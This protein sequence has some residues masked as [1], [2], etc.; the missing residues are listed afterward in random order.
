MSQEFLFKTDGDT[1]QVFIGTSVE[2]CTVML[3]AAYSAWGL[4]APST[5]LQGTLC[6]KELF[7]HNNK[8]P[9]GY[10][11]MWNILPVRY[12]APIEALEVSAACAAV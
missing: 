5:S 11:C 4:P 9:S 10:T 8:D 6:L 12:R 3:N 2:M 1:W 7:L